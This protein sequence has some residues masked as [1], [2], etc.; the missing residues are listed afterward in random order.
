MALGQWSRLTGLRRILL[1]G[2]VSNT[3]KAV[4]AGLRTYEPLPDFS[5]V[6]MKERPKLRF[7]NKVPDLVKVVK[8]PKNLNDIRGPAKEG[9]DFHEGEYGILALGGG[10]LHWG[11]FEMMRLTL[12]RKFDSRTTF[13]NWLIEAPNKPITRKGLGQRMGGGKG[14]VDHYVTPIKADQLILEVGGRCEFAEVL[15]MLTQ[16]AKKLPFPAI[17]VSRETLRQS[18]EEL[19]ERIKNNQNPWT[20]ERIISRNM[21]GCRKYLSPYDLHYKGRYW[22]KLCLKNRV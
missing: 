17:A 16:V 14:A 7:L 9:R 6:S 15:P 18:R 3:Q 20:F 13:S 4:T 8:A 5:R 1:Q 2:C 11:H 22:G 10:Y 21:M 12:N 19:E